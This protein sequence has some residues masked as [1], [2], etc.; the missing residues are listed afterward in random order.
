MRIFAVSDDKD[1]LAGLRLAGVEG[2]LIHEKR[3]LEA[4]VDGIQADSGVAVLL[5]SEGCAALIPET[6]KELKLSS[7]TP[8][9]VVIPDSRASN[10]EPDSIMGLIREAIGIK[11]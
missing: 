4:C 7:T 11:I 8:L 6:V 5:I 10:R 9:L 1:T 3:E 2:R